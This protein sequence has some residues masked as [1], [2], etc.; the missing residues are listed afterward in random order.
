MFKS[1]TVALAL[2]ALMAPASASAGLYAHYA[3]GTPAKKYNKWARL[4]KVSSPDANV[5]IREHAEAPAICG[6]LATACV[7]PNYVTKG[8]DLDIMVENDARSQ[9]LTYWHELGHVFDYAHLTDPLRNAFLTWNGENDGR[10]STE[11]YG[12][13]PNEVFART[14]AA[15]AVLGPRMRK[16]QVNYAEWSG[17]V[18]TNVK[19]HAKTCAMVEK[20]VL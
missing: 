15:C 12:S 7:Y 1:L 18:A 5:L 17:V 9:R 3:D 14:Y 2:V 19:R 8:Y 11:D 16:G 4:M 13:T 10:W 20:A 6:G